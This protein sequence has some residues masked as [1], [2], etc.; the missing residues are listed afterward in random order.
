MLS[1]STS[2]RSDQIERGEEL[3][4]QI[5]ELGINTI[6]L[7]YRISEAT[8]EEMLPSLRRGKVSVSSI[9]AF[10]P[11]PE[12]PSPSPSSA[13][14]EERQLAIKLLSRSLQIAQDLQARAVI[15]HLGE[16]P[17][18]SRIDE[19]CALFE[20]GLIPSQEWQELVENLKNERK[21]KSKKF[22][23][24]TLLTLDKLNKI[25]ERYEVYLAIENRYSFHEIPDFEELSVIL[26][27]F[28]GSNIGY[29]HDLG[30]ALAQENLGWVSQRKLLKAF[31]SQ[32]IGVHL[33]DIKGCGDDHWAPGQGEADFGLVAKYLSPDT[34]KVVEVLPKASKE[35]LLEGLQFLQRAGIG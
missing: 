4:G 14:P 30:H 35:E 8:F 12:I 3:L 11:K 25:A 9:H 21:A 23:D 7:D 20:R 27:E 32:M 13:D 5:L 2:W 26:K 16:I 22:L 34:L 24:Y 33:H 31:S 1:L 28:A 18:E 15:L 6:E 19:Q 17:M 29:W 10:F